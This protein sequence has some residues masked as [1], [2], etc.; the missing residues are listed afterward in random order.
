MKTI[1]YELAIAA[2]S[3]S[4]ADW[5]QFRGPTGLGFTVEKNLPLKWGGKDNANF[6]W[7]SPLIGQGHASPVVWGEAIF[8]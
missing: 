7:Q 1:F 2:F 3:V 4:A 8:V 6:L 5:P